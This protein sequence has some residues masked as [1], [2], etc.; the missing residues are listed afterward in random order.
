MPTEHDEAM[1]KLQ[2]IATFRDGRVV[3]KDSFWKIRPT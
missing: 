3:K 2:A 1:R